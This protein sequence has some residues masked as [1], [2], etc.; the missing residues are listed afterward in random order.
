[1]ETMKVV[2][3]ANTVK[4]TP[5]VS[6]VTNVRT[7]TTDQEGRHGMTATCAVHVT[8]T[9]QISP[10]TAKKKLVDVNVARSSNLQTATHVLMDTMDI[11]TAVSAIVILMVLMDITVKLS[12]V[13]ALANKTLLETTANNVLAGS[14]HSLNVKLVS[15]TQLDH[16]TT[17]V[18][19][20]MANVNV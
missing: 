19:L 14:S 6:I 5:K 15:A 7:L 8:V 3:F 12:M 9:D 13:S 17:I 20:K 10:E 1:M 18:M 4:T 2:V 16:S 11:P